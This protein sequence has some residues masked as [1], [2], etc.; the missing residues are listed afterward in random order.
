[1][2]FHLAYLIH[3]NEVNLIQ[4]LT[5]N[6]KIVAL[7]SIMARLSVFRSYTVSGCIKC[8]YSSF[9]LYLSSFALHSPEFS[10]IVF[11]HQV[12]T[13]ISSVWGEDHI[14]KL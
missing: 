11:N 4:F 12:I 10:F 7:P 6:S 8:N 2:C 5:V 1:M 13:L 3:W 14:A 9:I